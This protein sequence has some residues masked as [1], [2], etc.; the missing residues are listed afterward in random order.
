MTIAQLRYD[1]VA[2]TPW[3]EQGGGYAC[4]CAAGWMLIVGCWMML[5]AADE[6][7]RVLD[8]VRLSAGSAL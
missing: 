3:G 1:Y 4:C 8:R 2:A 5:N 6:R 7:G